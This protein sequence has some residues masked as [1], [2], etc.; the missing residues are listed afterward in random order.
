MNE[1]SFIKAFNFFFLLV[2][3]INMYDK[4]KSWFYYIFFKQL[5][6]QQPMYYAASTPAY[7]HQH[8]VPPQ[9][10]MMGPPPTYSNTA[11][12]YSIIPVAPLT[13]QTCDSGENCY[14]LQFWNASIFVILFVFKATNKTTNLLSIFKGWMNQATHKQSILNETAGLGRPPP[15]FHAAQPSGYVPM[16]NSPQVSI[17]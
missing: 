14:V 4:K 1:A 3:L 7:Q 11:P 10:F 16:Y 15:I 9:Q 2:D 17:L 12:S 8:H 13:H 6:L 5:P